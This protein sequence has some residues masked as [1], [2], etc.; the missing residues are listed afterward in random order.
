MPYAVKKDATGH[1]SAGKPWAVVTQG[2]E[3]DGTIHGC[4]STKAAAREQQK[5]LYANNP[6][7]KATDS[8]VAMTI[9]TN[10]DAEPRV[11]DVSDLLKAIRAVGRGSSDHDAARAHVIERAKALGHS[12]LVPDSWSA[13]GS[14]VE[15]AM[16]EDAE[17]RETYNDL[18]TA[19]SQ[20]LSDALGDSWSWWIQDLDDANVYYQQSSVLYSRPYSVEDGGP[21]TLGEPARVRPV[22]SYVPAESDEG[23]RSEPTPTRKLASRTLDWRRERAPR[24][25]DRET[26]QQTAP[27]QLRREDD[28]ESLL[29]TSYASLF[30]TPY[31]VGSGTYRYQE[32]VL[33]GA[34]KRTLNND[35]DVVFRAEHGG[36]PLAR[37]SSGTLRLIEDERGLRY[38]ADLNPSDP[39]VRSLI[40]K[41]ERGDLTESSFAFRCMEDTWN[42]DY[43]ERDLRACDLHRGDVS[44]VTFGAS[45]ATGEHMLLRSEEET[46]R[47]LRAYGVEAFIGAWAEWR[48]YTLLPPEA[49]AGKTL[50]ASTMEVLSNVL[51]LASTAE[52]AA[53]E[54]QSLLA[55]LMG[56]PNPEVEEA[57]A[58]EKSEKRGDGM[59]DCPVCD[60]TGEVDG[61]TC[62]ECDGT[63]EVEVAKDEGDDSAGGSERS[64]APSPAPS[65][66]SLRRE[67]RGKAA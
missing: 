46:L 15:K 42:D 25:G 38:E 48:D 24:R 21:V 66:R 16:W 39:D 50:S 13:D 31:T 62:S 6:D 44:I 4:F 67:L 7:A 59:V 34:F 43:S 57:K 33:P 53:E 3:N 60:G 41:I 17:A 47:A 49:R 5:A 27:L 29:L 61:E 20:A 28:G 55:D 11:A 14:L 1:C 23:A 35:P 22:T 10:A 19:V 37:T 36:P 58:E 45:P 51:S 12:D 30:D 2:G 9:K 65:L 8:E 63:G 18:Y 32:R 52:D 56:I 54:A 64:A 26:R 40:P